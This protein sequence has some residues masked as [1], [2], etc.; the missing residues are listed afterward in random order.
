MQNLECEKLHE[1]VASLKQQLSTPLHTCLS[2]ERP[3]SLN[4]LSQQAHMVSYSLIC[5]EK[6]KEK[7]EYIYLFIWYDTTNY[8]SNHDWIIGCPSEFIKNSL[9]HS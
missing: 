3:P 6:N 5:S 9:A 8:G 4:E 1:L 2:R 7:I